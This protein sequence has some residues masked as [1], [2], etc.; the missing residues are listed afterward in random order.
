MLLQN[1]PQG[2]N[3]V[4]KSS[5]SQ[6]LATAAI[7]FK[8]VTE[9]QCCFIVNGIVVFQVSFVVLDAQNCYVQEMLWICRCDGHLLSLCENET[10]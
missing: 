8:L 1:A 7:N 9:L 5:D 10:W 3:T 4:K 2:T 6:V